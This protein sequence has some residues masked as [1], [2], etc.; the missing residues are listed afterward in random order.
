MSRDPTTTR[1]VNPA[2]KEVLCR[3]QRPNGVLNGSAFNNMTV[4]KKLM[5]FVALEIITTLITKDKVHSAWQ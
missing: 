3:L 2:Y 5:V 1:V 4:T